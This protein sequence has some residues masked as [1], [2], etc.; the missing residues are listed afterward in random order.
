VRARQ[1]LIDR[2]G[3]SWF[4]LR[5]NF[6]RTA[7]TRVRKV[8]LARLSHLVS[9]ARSASG[10]ARGRRQGQALDQWPRYSQWVDSAT[11]QTSA[12]DIDE[13]IAVA[14]PPVSRPPL[15]LLRPAAC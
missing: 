11:R 2:G 7:T 9:V 3:H 10:R 8:R 5:C 1:R 13:C 6:L 15:P 14:L 4:V 12:G